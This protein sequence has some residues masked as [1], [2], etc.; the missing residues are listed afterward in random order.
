VA[1]D[2]GMHESTVSRATSN[3]WVST[4]HGIFEL[5][6]FF[7]NSIS[8]TDG[9]IASASVKAI[10]R[11]VIRKEDPRKPHS[12]EHIVALLS[13]RSINMARR[14]VAK[15]REEMGILPSWNRRSR[16]AKATVAKVTV[17]SPGFF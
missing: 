3:K 17:K 16:F 4:P 14:T 11:D 9:D 5:K 6:W 2:I 13:C 7:Q 12:D 8:K 1:A 15:Y 10:I